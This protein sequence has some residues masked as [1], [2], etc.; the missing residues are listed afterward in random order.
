[1][2]MNKLTIVI[3]AIPF[4]F[5]SCA[6]KKE[7]DIT[8]E[9]AS[10]AKET[11][12]ANFEM[13]SVIDNNVDYKL[14]KKAQPYL[15]EIKK[16]YDAVPYFFAIDTH[17]YFYVVNGN[18]KD[19]SVDTSKSKAQYKMGIV[20]KFNNVII[21]IEYNKIYN[22][23]G[24]AV[25]HI[26]VE[27]GGKRG[28]YHIS[29]RQVAPARFDYIYPLF[30][31][32]AL[33]Q[34]RTNEKFGLIH[35][36]GTVVFDGDEEADPRAF[37]SPYTSKIAEQWK[38]NINNK[39]IVYLQ[40]TSDDFDPNLIDSRAIVFTPS[41]LLELGF[42]PK[43]F[44]GVAT[45]DNAHFGL[46]EAKVEVKGIEN[47]WDNIKAV[48]TQYYEEGLAGR[49]Y[50]TEKEAVYSVDEN[51]NKIDGVEYYQTD[52]SRGI[53]GC[54]S[55]NNRLVLST[56]ND[57]IVEVKR[58]GKSEGD[59]G[60][61]NSLPY[62]YHPYYTFFSISKSGKFVRL[63]TNR[64]YN[65][66]KYVKIDESYFKGCFGSFIENSKTDENI[67]KSEHLSLEEME[68]MK[69]EI[70]ADYGFIFTTPKWK[71]YFS[72]QSWYMGL[73]SDVNDKLTEID[74]HNIKVISNTIN[75]MKDNPD[76]Y[77]KKVPSSS[78][79]FG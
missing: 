60:I 7:K 22:P 44:S 71:D 28:L 47:W 2:M 59:E 65:F 41:Y 3:F 27:K 21:P 29:G 5:F 37:Q 4:F 74:K 35:P 58:Y 61:E 19:P 6:D 11:D 50:I 18:W 52:M 46:K 66:T 57:T 15:I 1:M 34:I 14:F 67:M 70:F 43:Y 36:N 9:E 38:F 48:F 31:N 16:N 42:S 64:R 62:D 20:D 68:L 32:S 73:E 8:E 30:D 55:N 39:Q 63:K 51:G 17:Y 45:S 78:F 75:K 23:N 56:K 72:K 53:I 13:P 24:T 54:N 49:D 25:N 79:A 26:E 77:I 10:P 33:V 69:N 76:E 12:V 40:P